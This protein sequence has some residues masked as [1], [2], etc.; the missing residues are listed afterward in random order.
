MRVAEG[1]DVPI[2]VGIS[3]RL[4]HLEVHVLHVFT[5]VFDP[6]DC[7]VGHG[8]YAGVSAT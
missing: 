2:A 7:G 5:S 1:T 6:V 4:E 8:G 3:Q